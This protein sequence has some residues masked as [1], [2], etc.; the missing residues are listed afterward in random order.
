MVNLEVDLT[1]E[2][3]REGWELRSR[4]GAVKPDGC[5][6]AI[7]VQRKDD[8]YAFATT[9][10]IETVGPDGYNRYRLPSE[11]TDLV[12]LFD[13]GGSIAPLRFVAERIDD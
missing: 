5:P 2:D 8:V 7:A 1:V 10:V 6:I 12:F 11:A 4:V 3:I 9:W 13:E